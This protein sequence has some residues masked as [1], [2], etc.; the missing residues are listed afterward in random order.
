MTDKNKPRVAFLT[1][2]F[3]PEVP[4]GRERHVDH[5][6]RSLAHMCDI[7]IYT[8]TASRNFREEHRDNLKI[9]HVPSIQIVVSENPRL[10]YRVLPGL[11][12]RLSREHYDVVHA[13]EYG[14][15]TTDRAA[16]FARRRSVPFLLTVYG[17]E[18]EGILPTLLRGAYDRTMGRF[19][20]KT[21]S[22]ILFVSE[23][24]YRELVRIFGLELLADK[25]HIVENCIDI[26][27]AEQP[28]SAELVEKVKRQLECDGG[29]LILAVGRLI[30]RKGFAHLIRAM[31]MIKT[32]L[33]S[34][35]LVIV[36][37][38]MGALRELKALALQLGIEGQIRFMGQVPPRDI[39]GI[40]AACDVFVVPSTY[41]GLPLAMLE[42]M[43][44]SRPIV[45][46]DL[47]GIGRVITQE[48]EG[49]LVPPMDTFG[50][51]D[52]IL[53]LLR[54][55]DVAAS[56]GLRAR[57]RVA[58]FTSDREAR[59]VFDHYTKLLDNCGTVDQT[60]RFEL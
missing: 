11:G 56:M 51:A 24:Q 32:R 42:A 55:P 4:G 12:R 49:Y 60:K 58:H 40:L 23:T 25:A 37:P 21:A 27:A 54:N 15:Y 53:H 47:D 57:E 20:I 19:V 2:T 44:Q 18:V 28:P 39:P 33:P 52:R 41:E 16:F 45:A 3:I 1:H 36:G 7:T 48:K 34:A 38:D 30:P 8:G 31:S 43:A 14:C 17:Y 35:N 22:R 9:V 59:L 5:L 26:D 50:L 10:V 6:A 46:S 13:F 29:A